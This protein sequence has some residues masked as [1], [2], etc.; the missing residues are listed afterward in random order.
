MESESSSAPRWLPGFWKTL[1]RRLLVASTLSLAVVCSLVNWELEPRDPLRRRLES[2]APTLPFDNKTVPPTQQ[3]DTA[4]WSLPRL[5]SLGSQATCNG[6]STKIPRVAHCIA[7]NARTLYDSRAF[8]TIQDHFINAFGGRY[9]TFMYLKLEDDKL[10]DQNRF[11]PKVDRERIQHAI[12]VL[13]PTSLVIGNNKPKSDIVNTGCKLPGF[14]P[15]V[16]PRLLAQLDT[17]RECFRLVE[18]YESEHA[19]TFDW[20]TRLRPDTAIVFPVKPHCF[21]DEAFTYLPGEIQHD[22][23][24]MEQTGMYIDHGKMIVFPVSFLV[25]YLGLSLPLR[26][27]LAGIFPRKQAEGLFLAI[28]EYKR[29]QGSMDWRYGG[30]KI[31]DIQAH[32]FWDRGTKF[33]IRTEQIPVVLLRERKRDMKQMC[34][35]QYNGEVAKWKIFSMKGPDLCEQVMSIDQSP[36]RRRLR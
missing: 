6:T 22:T 7:G 18:A 26:R 33:N 35:H 10:L 14:N 29:C 21:F 24:S 4:D 1:R 16:L 12:D 36:G 3:Q 30:K 17:L 9:N 34:H 15:S 11:T 2:I 8:N 25:S 5:G 31:T 27:A 23:S 13:K 20:V 28:E 19:I 32:L